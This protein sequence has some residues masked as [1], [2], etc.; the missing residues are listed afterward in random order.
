MRDFWMYLVA[1]FGLLVVVVGL[2][3]LVTGGPT[4]LNTV[5]GIVISMLLSYVVLGRLR[6]AFTDR[7]VDAVEQRQAKKQEA[8]RKKRASQE[9]LEDRD[10][11][12]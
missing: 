12:S 4:L 6:E 3:W 5:I 2:I 1:R 7:A 9:D 10:L 11:D 8:A